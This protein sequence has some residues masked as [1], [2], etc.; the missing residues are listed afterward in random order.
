MEIVR[1]FLPGSLGRIIE[2]HGAYYAR[3]WELGHEFETTVAAGLSEF[4]TRFQTGSDLVLLGLIDGRVCTSLILDLHDPAGATWFNDDQSAHLR[5][6]IVDDTVRGTGLGTILLDQAMAHVDE[7]CEGRCWLTTFA[8]LD[9]A[10]RAYE[11]LGFVLMHETTGTT[12][13]RPLTEQ[14]FVRPAPSGPLS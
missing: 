11:R 1:R 6:F 4:A 5:Y 14:V 2:M 9:A 3:K 7:L 13:G 10:R 12:W 8:G